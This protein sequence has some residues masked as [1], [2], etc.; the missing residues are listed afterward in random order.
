MLNTLYKVRAGLRLG[1][2]VLLMALVPASAGAGDQPAWHQILPGL[3]FALIRAEASSRS[4]SAN[5]AALRVDPA[6]HRFR[7]LAAPPGESGHTAAEWLEKSGALAVF[8]AGQYAADR[9][10]LGL[11]VVDGQA[12]GHLA[13]K[14]EAL[15]LAEPDDPALPPA[16]VLDLRYTAFDLRTNPYRQAAQSHMLLD[17]FGQIR[18]RRSPVVAHRT[19]VAEDTSG[20]IL[21]LVSEGGH[22][23]WELANFLKGSGLGLREVMSMDGA[24][25]SQLVVRAG[26]FSYRQFGAPTGSPEILPWPVTSLPVALGVFPRR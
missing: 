19:A 11:L 20:R 21:V 3:E 8:N 23:L 17:R 6:R 2:A 9:T 15:F 10:Y 14:L 18:V 5:L 1:L 24:G 22:T 26:G 7:V 12:R 13:S 16:R 4:G 25:E